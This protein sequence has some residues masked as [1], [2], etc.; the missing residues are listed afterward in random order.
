MCPV[1]IMTAIVFGPGL[2]TACGINWLG[3]KSGSGDAGNSAGTLTLGLGDGPSE[4][5]NANSE[6]AEEHAA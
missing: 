1:C 2:L 6:V 5:Q 3:K 4:N